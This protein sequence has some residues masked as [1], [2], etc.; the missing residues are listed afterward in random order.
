ML[1]SGPNREP[2]TSSGLTTDGRN[3][4]AAFAL[5]SG[6]IGAAMAGALAVPLAGPSGPRTFMPSIALSYG[7]VERP[8][9]PRALQLAHEVAVGVCKRLF[10]DWGWEDVD[11]RNPVQVYS[12]N[13][14][15]VTE[16]IERANRKVC[17]TTMWRNTY[18]QLF[19]P[20]QKAPQEE[21]N[22]SAADKV[23]QSDDA[24]SQQEVD[25]PLR[26]RFAPNFHPL[27]HPSPDTMSEGTDAWA[28]YHGYTSV[29]PLLANFAELQDPGQGFG[30]ASNGRFW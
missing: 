1:I 22:W 7:V 19:V 8:V 29:T 9:P 6:T 26:F 10:D 2:T 25:G 17:F 20:T 28:F 23:Q 24:E 13:V 16:A 27:L 15:L 21:T 18:G 4:S 30:D 3:L 14:P 11:K 5:S 12:V